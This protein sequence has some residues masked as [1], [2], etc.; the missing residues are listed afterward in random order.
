MNYALLGLYQ[1]IT[2]LTTPLAWCLFT[3]SYRKEK[4][5]REWV[6]QRMGK[7]RSL[8]P[9]YNKKVIWIH[10]A[11]IG[12]LRSAGTMVH[13]LLEKDPDVFILLTTQSLQAL[14]MMQKR[15]GSN[16][17][18]ALCLAPYD[19]PWCVRRF[20][21]QWKPHCFCVLEAEIW[22]C[23]WR[24]IAKN[25]MRSLLVNFHISHASARFWQCLWPLFTALYRP[26]DKRYSGCTAS[27][28]RFEQL[29]QNTL[30]MSFS[31]T[32]KYADA[33]LNHPR[34]Q[35]Q[36]PSPWKE[37]PVWMASCGHA[38]DEPFFYKAHQSLLKRNP[39]TLWIYAPRHMHRVPDIVK[40]CQQHGWT[41]EQHSQKKGDDFFVSPHCHV[42]IIDTL[43]ELDSFYQKLSFVIMGGSFYPSGRGHNLI[44]PLSCLC[45]PLYGPYMKNCW[46]VVQD[47][48][49]HGVGQRVQPHDLYA[50][51]TKILDQP[52]IAW[53]WSDRGKKMLQ[54][55]Q[56]ALKKDV[57]IIVNTML[58]HDQ[59]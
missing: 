44:E 14:S 8:T 40:Q 27:T 11:D 48:L 15:I 18:I 29:T 1:S 13:A 6:S 2:L 33:S 35:Q 51:I 46:D 56:R 32:L 37:R 10:G 57:D 59:P 28:R 39:D 30:H 4:K 34:K 49:H 53:E 25:R 20:L 31:P 55:R 7:T 3:Y 50:A 9:P 12:E 17:Q 52:A 23:L 24:H 45:A 54:D 19:S 36:D 47:C 43:G 21:K 58:D 38:K 22:P 26:F 16:N 42:Y 41:T 5:R